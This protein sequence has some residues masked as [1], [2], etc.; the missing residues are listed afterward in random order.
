MNFLVAVQHATIGYGIRRRVWPPKAMLYMQTYELYWVD[1]SDT[2]VKLLGD[3]V[4]A[5]LQK[6]DIQGEDWEAI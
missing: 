5:D 4:T 2:P 3:S 6:E 1:G